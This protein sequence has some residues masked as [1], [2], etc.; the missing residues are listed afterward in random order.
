MKIKILFV[1]RKFHIFFSLEK[2]FRQ[3]AK[4]L[5]N[6]KFEI[7]FQQLPYINNLSG[8]L[9]NFLFFRRQKADIYHVT[10]HIHYITLAFPPEKTVLTIHDLAF[11]H[12]RAGIRR[13]VLKK[14]LLDLPVRKLRF[15]TAVSEATKN[16]IV[17]QTDCAADKIR[18][19]EN[20][21]DG[22]FFAG[23]EK[24]FNAECPT[25]L[26]IGTEP[27]KNL[28]NLLKAIEDINCRLVI[29]GKLTEELR[30][31]LNEKQIKYENKYNLDD[32]K[33]QSE[34][35]KADIVTF[36]SL[37]EGF[38]LPIV[39]AQAM[40]TPVVTSDIE[41]MRGVAGEGACLVDPKD[42][43]SIRAGI[44]RIIDDKI[45]RENLI[46]KG[47]KNVERFRPEK[48]AAQYEALYEE[49]LSAKS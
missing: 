47:L 22:I 13:F 36:C 43:L 5:N 4:S 29:I 39:E 8:M 31:L 6:E 3:I 45:F 12:T 9:K 26:Q 48:I 46:Q 34:Y 17:A 37:Y 25:V 15:I 19:V 49:M 28:P 21:V 41:P 38:G 16:E 7:S 42:F 18:V 30:S 32:K 23:L 10:G 35:Q 33:V 20:P 27:H 11:L 2:V 44:Q 40:Q 14:I 24:E 1:E